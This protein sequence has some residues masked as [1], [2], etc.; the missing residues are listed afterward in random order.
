MLYI[1][2]N[3]IYKDLLVVSKQMRRDLVSTEGRKSKRSEMLYL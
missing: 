1:Y 3:V 2:Y